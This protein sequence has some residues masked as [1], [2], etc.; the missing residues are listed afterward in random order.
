MAISILRR[1]RRGSLMN[2]V[3]K[4]LLCIR[5]NSEVVYFSLGERIFLTFKANFMAGSH[6]IPSSISFSSVNNIDAA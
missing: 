5:K 3:F 2:K 4:E 6:F 1:R